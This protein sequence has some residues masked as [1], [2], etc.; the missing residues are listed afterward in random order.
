MNEAMDVSKTCQSNQNLRQTVC[1]NIRNYILD[2]QLHPGTKLPSEAEFASILNVSRTSLREGIRMLEGAGFIEC[3]Q[4]D[5]MYVAEYSG[6]R[7]LDYIQYSMRFN[8]E[9][10]KDIYDVRNYLEECFVREACCKRTEDQL[11]RLK[12]IVEQ[13]DNC[14]PLEYHWLDRDFHLT[15]FENISNRLVRHLMELYWDVVLCRW[16]PY[17]APRIPGMNVE[18][19]K[20]IIRAIETG[21]PEAA[22]ASMIIH[23][24]ETNTI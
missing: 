11:T 18:N 20:T 16:L 14:E 4:G 19:H 3:K 13:M 1:E 10:I 5:G 6:A 17:E 24:A 22:Y 2:N 8:K 23:M 7:L 9:D 15:L 12:S 21:N